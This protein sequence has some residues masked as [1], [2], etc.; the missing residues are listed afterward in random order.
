MSEIFGSST[1]LSIVG[2]DIFIECDEPLQPFVD[3]LKHVGFSHDPRD[4][5]YKLIDG[6]QKLEEIREICAF[7]FSSGKN[8]TPGNRKFVKMIE[9]YYSDG[10]GVADL[11]FKKTDEGIWVYSMSGT[12]GSAL[13]MSE[14]IRKMRAKIICIRNGRRVC[15]NR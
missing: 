5:K 4:Q 14:D 9:N 7:Y 8:M 2:N 11:D 1:K 3:E 15:F 10:K 12:Y 13:E 6:K